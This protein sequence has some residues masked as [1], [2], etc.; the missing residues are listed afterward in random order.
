MSGRYRSRPN[1]QYRNKFLVDQGANVDA[2]LPLDMPRLS[3]PDKVHF[4]HG[5]RAFSLGASRN[6]I[7]DAVHAL[8]QVQSGRDIAPFQPQMHLHLLCKGRHAKEEH[9]HIARKKSCSWRAPIP[10][11][12]I[13]RTAL[14]FSWLLPFG[15]PSCAETYLGIPGTIFVDTAAKPPLAWLLWAVTKTSCF[16]CLLFAGGRQKKPDNST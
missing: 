4:Y 10:L 16:V 14:P 8:L 9:I 6:H 15:A 12:L 1:Q 2:P 11:G 5:L 7:V 3:T 13:G